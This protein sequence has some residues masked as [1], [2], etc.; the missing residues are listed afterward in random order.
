[1]LRV[2][3][4][5][6]VALGVCAPAYATL[7][8]VVPSRDGLAIAS[9]SRLTFMGAQCDGAFK[10]LAPARPARTVA[11]VTGDGVFVPP[12]PADET[13]PCRYLATAP[14]QLDI[15]AAVVAT[16]E[17]GGDAAQIS[18][19]A[20]AAA[21]VNAVEQFRTEHPEALR[22]YAGREMFSVVVASYDPQKR[23]AMLRNFVVRLD[24]RTL[25]AQAARMTETA[26]TP[27]TAG[28]VWIYGE[29]EWVNRNVYA[30]AGR[31]FLAPHTIEFLGARRPVRETPMNLA[32][33]T[34]ANVIAAASRAAQE[35]PPPSGIG[36]PLRVMVV[37]SSPRPELAPGSASH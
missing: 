7:V 12:P 5:V 16:L 25:H 10:I 18:M 1:M 19:A 13:D 29:T 34:A 35:T 36:G 2:F 24:P 15:G 32:A 23:A 3:A 4:T 31:R 30:G 33:A 17:R 11:I 9:D 8:A 6:L 21:C 26:V 28:G 20:V 14:R 27:Q 37:G 22:R